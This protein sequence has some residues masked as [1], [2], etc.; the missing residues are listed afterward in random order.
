M[1]FA[2]WVIPLSIEL[3]MNQNSIRDFVCAGRWEGLLEE[4]GARWHRGG[5][6]TLGGESPAETQEEKTADGA[7]PGSPSEV[8]AV[9]LRLL[10]TE[11][12]EPRVGRGGGPWSS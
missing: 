2:Q 8:P 7:T 5:E 9:P 12:R 4:P 1:N 10:P 11:K 6:R 3:M